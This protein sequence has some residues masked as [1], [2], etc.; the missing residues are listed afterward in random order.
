MNKPQP[1][2]IDVWATQAVRSLVN[3]C[4]VQ[5]SVVLWWLADLVATR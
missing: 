5:A 1:T 3:N 2:P 4:E